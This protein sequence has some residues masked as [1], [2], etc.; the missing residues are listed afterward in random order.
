MAV[1]RLSD[2]PTVN[3]M[4]SDDYI[5]INQNK[6]IKQ[7]KKSEFLTAADLEIFSRVGKTSIFYNSGDYS[8]PKANIETGTLWNTEKNNEVGV[9][10]IIN[11]VSNKNGFKVPYDGT[12]QFISTILINTTEFPTGVQFTGIINKND[13][14]QD[15]CMEVCNGFTNVIKAHFIFNVK[16]AAEDILTFTMSQDSGVDATIL[17]DYSRLFITYLG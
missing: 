14:Q 4:E 10:Y 5:I 3:S 17:G 16:A 1:V 7:I 15:S 13:I 12:Y 11:S 8:L 9:E 6:I 2:V